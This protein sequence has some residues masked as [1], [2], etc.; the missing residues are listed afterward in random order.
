MAMIVWIVRSA[1]V[2]A[3]EGER[4]GAVVEVVVVGRVD[5]FSGDANPSTV[6]RRALLA[7]C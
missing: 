6:S 1:S 5:S 2:G 4:R 7:I 3:G